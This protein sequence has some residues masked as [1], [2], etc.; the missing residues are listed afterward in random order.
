MITIGL[1]G[2]GDHEKLYEG[3]VKSKDKLATYA[4]H[5][6]C[7]EV[8]AYFYAIQAERTVKNWIGETPETFKFIVKAYQGMTGHDRGNERYSSKTEMFQEYLDSIRPFVQSNKLA[9]ILFQFPPWFDYSREHFLYLNYVKQKM[10]NLPVAIEFRNQSWYHRKNRE[11]TLRFLK[12]K[13][14][15][16]SIADE[17]QA[18]DGSVP[19]VAVAT[20]TATT[21]VRLH[22]RNKVGWNRPQTK[23]THWREVRYLYRYNKQELQSLKQELETLAKQT[24]HLYVLFNNNSGLDASDNA[25]QLK[26]MLNIDEDGLAPRQLSLF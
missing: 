17:P 25:K 20:S 5:F 8:D 19:F 2:W 1:T 26:D 13:E 9:A 22:G 4:G 12:E 15:I 11:E 21:I 24:N 3:K 10:G 23:D 7:V 16:H 14:F 6:L 18:G